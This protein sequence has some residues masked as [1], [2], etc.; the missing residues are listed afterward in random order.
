VIRDA[1]KLVVLGVRHD[2]GHRI[3]EPPV[4]AQFQPG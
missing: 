2:P 4:L 1:A 3:T